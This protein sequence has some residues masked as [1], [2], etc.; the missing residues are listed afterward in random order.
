MLISQEEAKELIQSR[1]KFD[2]KCFLLLQSFALVGEK[3][4]I[5]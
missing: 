1:E 3:L 4:F 5:E 2:I